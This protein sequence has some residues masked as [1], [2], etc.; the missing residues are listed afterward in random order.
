MRGSSTTAAT[1]T[2][3]TRPVSYYAKGALVA[4]AFDLTLRSEGRGTL[5]DVM[6]RL[7]SGSDGG[8]IDEADI[9][10]ALEA[11]GGRSFS[12]ELAAVGAR[13]RRAAAG[14][15]LPR[16]GVGVERQP[17][18][19]AQRLGVRVSES[20]LTGVKVTH[21]LRGRAAEGIGLA[22]GDE[23]IGVG[24]WRLRRLD[25]AL[26]YVG[27]AA[28]WPPICVAR[29]Q[30]LLELRFDAGLPRRRRQAAR[31][32]APCRRRERRG[33][34]AR[35]GMDFRLSRDPATEP[36][37]R[38]RRCLL[39]LLVLAVVLAHA[40]L[41]ARLAERMA[42]IDARGED[43]AADRGRLRQDA[44]ARGAQAA[45]APRPPPPCAAAAG[46]AGRREASSRRV[47]G[48]GAAEVEEPPPTARGR[49]AASPGRP[50]SGGRARAA[51]TEPPQV[52]AE[53]AAPASAAGGVG[54]RGLRLAQG[55]PRQLPAHRQLARRAER[56]R[57]GRVDQ[58]RRPLPGER[59]MHA[60]PE[61]APLV[62]RRMTSEGRSSPTAWR[63][64]AT[65]R[66][67]GRDAR[68][69]ADQHGLR[70]PTW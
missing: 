43:A 64:S 4:L 6:Q 8:P 2:R 63:R 31:S 47:G 68:G 61:V 51:R 20:A 35:R 3:R 67:P 39:C 32:A 38:S 25:D 30:R 40:W 62:A 49:G 59:A 9:A 45:G 50:R 60:G 42:E 33:A 22:A 69:P 52:V 37:R 48:V 58:D 15:L 16:F 7:W 41:T 44:R 12:A 57:R 55:D 27:R 36:V 14:E 21:V 65:R 56:P 66:R 34:A 10:A 29:D 23:L 17:A 18:T 54:G 28:P 70:G 24:G 26:R 1:R 13:Y 53:A 11:V 5:D 19:L 46:A